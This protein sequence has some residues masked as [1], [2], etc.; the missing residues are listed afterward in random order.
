MK[1]FTATY[2][3]IV[4]VNIKFTLKILKVLF[5]KEFYRLQAIQNRSCFLVFFFKFMSFL[6]KLFQ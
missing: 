5:A 3:Q 1:E 6:C 4:N 2:H